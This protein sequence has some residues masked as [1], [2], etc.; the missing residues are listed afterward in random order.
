MKLNGRFEKPETLHNYGFAIV[1]NIIYLDVGMAEHIKVPVPLCEAIRFMHI[2][3]QHTSSYLVMPFNAKL[4]LHSP[5][6]K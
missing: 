5:Q 6:L 1:F 4:I 3:K 2:M